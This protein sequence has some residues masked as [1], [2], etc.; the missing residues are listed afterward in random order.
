MTD[1]VKQ[2]KTIEDVVLGNKYNTTK[3]W[4]IKR[5]GGDPDESEVTEIEIPINPLYIIQDPKYYNT[6]GQ[7]ES[8]LEYFGKLEIKFDIKITCNFSGYDGQEPKLSIKIP[9]K[10]ENQ[11]AMFKFLDAIKEDLQ[12]TTGMEPP[13]DWSPV[14]KKGEWYNKYKGCLTYT[15]GEFRGKDFIYCAMNMKTNYMNLLRLLGSDKHS[16]CIKFFNKIDEDEHPKLAEL[17]E[18]SFSS[19]RIMLAGLSYEN[20]EIYSNSEMIRLGIEAISCIS[21]LFDKEKPSIKEFTD[22]CNKYVIPFNK[23]ALND[24]DWYDKTQEH[25]SPDGKVWTSNITILPFQIKTSVYQNIE[26][27]PN[28]VKTGLE[29]MYNKTTNITRLEYLKYLGKLNVDEAIKNIFWIQSKDE[30]DDKYERLNIPFSL[31]YMNITNKDFSKKDNK[32]TPSKKKCSILSQVEDFKK[33][34][35]IKIPEIEPE[36]EMQIVNS[37]QALAVD[38]DEEA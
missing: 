33:S 27:L 24:K 22:I 16:K 17:D 32:K 29:K 28:E 6:H 34:K 19:E 37:F 38:S 20:E 13:E 31:G 5:N 12:M 26:K 15:E 1:T 18:S 7:Y 14:I 9:L 36:P 11:K 4:E 21:V 25:T 8:F 10:N 23:I 35:E 3:Y 30:Y 2:T